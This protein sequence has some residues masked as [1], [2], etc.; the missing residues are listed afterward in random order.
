VIP[1]KALD[2]LATDRISI[3]QLH[4]AATTVHD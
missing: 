3:E 1:A 2:D 4:A